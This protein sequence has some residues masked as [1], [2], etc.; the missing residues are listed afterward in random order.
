VFRLVRTAAPDS[1]IIA[2]GEVEQGGNH[3]GVEWGAALAVFVELPGALVLN[4]A[5]DGGRGGVGVAPVQAA[6]D[7]AERLALRRLGDVAAF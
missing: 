2:A 3:D 1:H 6:D 5:E 4:D 7:A